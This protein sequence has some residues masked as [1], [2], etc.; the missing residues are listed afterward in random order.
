MKIIFGSAQLMS[1]HGINND[2]KNLKIPKLKEI[3]KFLKDKK[4]FYIDTAEAYGSAEKIIGK[5]INSKF[6]II[7]KISSLKKYDIDRLDD[8]I[9]HK[10]NQSLYKL[11]KFM[12]F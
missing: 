5:L 11:I 3:F 2:D 9:F 4:N 1:D 6:K 12:E 7:T 10:V 8:V